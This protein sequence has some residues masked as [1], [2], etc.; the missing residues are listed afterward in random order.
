MRSALLASD[1]ALLPVQPSPFDGWASAETLTLIDEARTPPPLLVARFVLNHCTAR[2]VIA[3]ET[4][5]ALADHDPPLL[6]Q[7]IGQRVAFADAAKTG[8]LVW[9]IGTAQSRRPRRQRIR[10]RSREDRAMTIL[11]AGSHM[12]VADKRL[13]ASPF[14]D[15]P[16]GSILLACDRSIN[17]RLTYWRF[18][19]CRHLGCAIDVQ[20]TAQVRDRV[21]TLLPLDRGRAMTERPRRSQFAARPGD[22][23]SRIKSPEAPTL[24]AA[25]NGAFTARLTIDVTSELRGR[26]KVTAFQRGVTVADMLR[27]ILAKALPDVDGGMP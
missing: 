16:D 24:A 1:L 5:A 6:R 2:T 7:R 13:T 26:I 20:A 9:E 10:Q 27:E 3:S 22:V 23:E 11:T 15:T 12:S 21:V 25:K 17:R 4:A 19:R 18:G 8:R 14:T